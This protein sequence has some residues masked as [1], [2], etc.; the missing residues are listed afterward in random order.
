MLV[1]GVERKGESMGKKYVKVFLI[2]CVTASHLSGIGAE[3]GG[4]VFG[5]PLFVKPTPIPSES[6]IQQSLK[7]VKE[8][9]EEDAKALKAG[10]IGGSKFA[11]RLMMYS[12]QTDNVSVKFVLFRNAFRQFLIGGD[13]K[14]AI[15]LFEKTFDS[16][17][18]RFTSE[19]VSYS[20]S[21]LRNLENSPKSAEAIRPLKTIVEELVCSCKELADAEAVLQSHPEDEKT[22]RK[23]ALNAVKLMDWGLA[24]KIYVELGG[25][26]GDIC[27]WELAVPELRGEECTFE[28]C[29]DYW[30]GYINGKDEQGLL[31]R[32]VSRHA[33]YWYQRALAE[34][35]M[36]ELKSMLVKK[37]I[38]RLNVWMGGTSSAV[39]ANDGDGESTLSGAASAVVADS[40]LL[41]DECKAEESCEQLIFFEDFENNTMKF[42][43]TTVGSFPH[44]ACIQTGMGVNGSRGFGFGRSAVAGN[45]HFK[46]VNTL[47]ATFKHRYYITKVEFDEME[48]YG[49]TGSVGNIIVNRTGYERLK[50]HDFCRFPHNDGKADKKFRH[51]NIEIGKIGTSI[52]FQVVDIAGG[53]EEFIDNVKIYGRQVR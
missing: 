6:Q 4:I 36:A 35:K 11:Q 20:M 27:R 21:T 23:I 31:Y 7:I 49:N 28:Q 51:R 15:A 53:S 52:S 39:T 14:N 46:Y 50:N 17:G 12:Q 8:L 13:I 37:R 1:F 30:W 34:G 40:R 41:T 10:R 47:T 43:L 19:M 18:G 22:K 24:L 45:A 25:E 2:L 5:K 48:R 26:R 38:A 42:S 3:D 29:G 32:A 33:A 9:C 44:P 16:F